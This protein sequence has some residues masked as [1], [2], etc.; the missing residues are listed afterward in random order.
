M[1]KSVNHPPTLTITI[2]GES[3]DLFMSFGLLDTL[4][5]IVIDP[6]RIAAIFTEPDLREEILK[7]ALAHRRKSGKVESEIDLEDTDISIKDV[8]NVLQWVAD[9]V[10]DFLLR[11]LRKVVEVTE[12]NKTLL[13]GLGSSLTGLVGSPS[14]SPSAGPSE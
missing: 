11:S 6:S 3:R 2:D 4:S 13:Q 5:R 14:P 10:M 7:A 1:S 8:E 9:H 12:Q